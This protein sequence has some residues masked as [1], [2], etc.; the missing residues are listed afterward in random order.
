MNSKYKYLKLNFCKIGLVLIPFEGVL[1]RLGFPVQSFSLTLLMMIATFHKWNN[2]INITPVLKLII[3]LLGYLILISSINLVLEPQLL[4]YLTRQL[5]SFLMGIALFV[6]LRFTFLRLT[7]D[8]II[9]YIV[10]GFYIVSIFSV[11]DLARGYIRIRS[12]YSEPSY[13]AQ[14]LSLIIFPALMVFGQHL[15]RKRKGILVLLMA[16]QLLLTWSTTGIVRIVMVIA[17]VLIF[18]KDI[19]IWTKSLI[20]FALC[21]LGYLANVFLNR[22]FEGNYVSMM[23]ATTVGLLR[24][25]QTAPISFV[26]RAIFVFVLTNLSLSWRS[27][28]GYGFGGEGIY[29][30]KIL[31]KDVAELIA[32]NKQFGFSINSLWAKFL[33]YGGIIGIAIYIAVVMNAMR[34]SDRLEKGSILKGVIFSIFLSESIGMAAFNITEIWFWLAYVDARSLQYRRMTIA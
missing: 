27:I 30:D 1:F 13:L 31:T 25:G 18:S 9:T 7:D 12:L 16:T 26:D 23:I 21:A 32:A 33:V 34:E 3:A 5:V 28:L 2:R 22:A 24:A 6:F 8:Q 29:H 19:S 20:V 11:L 17:S 15:Q 10:Y 4:P 14:Y